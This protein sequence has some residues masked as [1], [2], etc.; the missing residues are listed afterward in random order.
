MRRDIQAVLVALA[1]VGALSAIGVPAR[2]ESGPSAAS[3][4]EGK[5]RYMKYCATCH[6]PSATGDG[7]AASTFKTKPTNLT[8]LAKQNGGKFPT[9]KVVDIVKGDTPIAAH[10]GREMPVWG[11]ILG[12]PLDSHMYKQDE[13]DLKIL[14]IANYLQSI[15]QK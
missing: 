8:L 12:H 3:I 11:D 1:T 9:M 14:P 15:Q 13:V 6:G 10:G 5:Q 7:I 4:E 2:A